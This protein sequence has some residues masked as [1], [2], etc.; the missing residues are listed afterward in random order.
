MSIVRCTYCDVMPRWELPFLTSREDDFLLLGLPI[1]I[2]DR[3][4]RVPEFF[5]DLENGAW[6]SY[7]EPMQQVC[8]AFYTWLQANSF[9]SP[10]SLHLF[11]EPFLS[12]FWSLALYTSQWCQEILYR[13]SGEFLEDSPGRVGSTRKWRHGVRHPN[14]GQ[15]RHREELRSVLDIP[16]VSKYSCVF[17]VINIFCVSC[18]SW[19]ISIFRTN[20]FNVEFK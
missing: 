20:E 2:A 17:I 16:I 9:P 19:I 18:L 8:F 1:S 5:Y 6:A 10:L 4:W 3:V 14:H 7:S 13:I 12:I 15:H 11:H